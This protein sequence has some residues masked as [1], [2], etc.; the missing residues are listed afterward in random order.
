MVMIVYS[1]I[2]F[3]IM[4]LHDNIIEFIINYDIFFINIFE[5]IIY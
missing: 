2:L 1:M 5:F 3:I 4:Y